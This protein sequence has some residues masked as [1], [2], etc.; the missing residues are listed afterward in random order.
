LREL[1]STLP[2]KPT[3]LSQ[4]LLQ[5]TTQIAPLPPSALPRVAGGQHLLWGV[6]AALALVSSS[7]HCSAPPGGSAAATPLWAVLQ[8]QRAVWAVGADARPS[9]GRHAVVNEVQP[10]RIGGSGGGNDAFPE[11]GSM[12]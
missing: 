5:P 3:A 6:G 11:V 10:P 7:R 2:P 12:E 1:P 4:L 9:G 8:H